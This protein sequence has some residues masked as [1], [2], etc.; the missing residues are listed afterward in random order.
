VIAV[1]GVMANGQPYA[2]LTGTALEGSF[3]PEAAMKGAIAAYTPNIPWARIACPDTID[4]DGQGTSAST[5][6]IAAAVALWYEKY[7][8]VLPRDWRRVEA[9]RNALFSSA[10]KQ[11]ATHFGQGILQARAAL[12][13]APQLNLPKTPEESD[14]FS[15][16][17]VLTG[18]GVTDMPG[19]EAM[20]N[21]ELTQRWLVN[22]ELQAAVPDPGKDVPM[23][24]IKQFMEAAIHDGKASTALRKHLADRYGQVFATA[25]P[26][27]PPEIVSPPQA[28]CKVT[29][30]I[31]DPP[32]RRLR[33]YGVDPSFSTDLDT[34]PINEVVLNVKWENT[35][36]PGPKGEYVEVIDEDAAGITYAPV[37]LNDPRLLSTDGCQPAEG[38]PAFHQ[39]A[40]YTVS[41]T[42]IAFF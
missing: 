13:I 33:V 20:F 30:E 2:G 7:K 26:G 14:S 8:N 34:A 29:S 3:G 42:T 23:S 35:L 27:A 10:K 39:Q 21:L 32:F 38:N 11:D 24:A 19:K 16:F 9:V 12:D 40:V 36:E 6:Q 25:V 5:P 4:L 18:L 1:C 28:A 22:Q 17:R 41:M 15:F 31:S 37:N